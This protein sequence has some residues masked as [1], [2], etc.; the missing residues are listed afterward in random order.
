M[1]E[2]SGYLQYLPP[3][4][5]QGDP[6]PPA[7]SLSAA[8]RIFEK[9]VFRMRRLYCNM[10]N[11]RKKRK[12]PAA[13]PSSARAESQIKS[14][15]VPFTRHLWGTAVFSLRRATRMDEN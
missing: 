14:T 9:G 3:V 2:P 5:W 4:L 13:T 15:L 6:A 10:R 1:T 8:L 7:F 12:T 11:P